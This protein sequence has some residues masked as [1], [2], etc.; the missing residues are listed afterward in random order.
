MT[1]GQPRLLLRLGAGAAPPLLVPHPDS[2]KAM[3][4]SGQ[5]SRVLAPSPQI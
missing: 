4:L 2:N 3:E 1:L 5:I